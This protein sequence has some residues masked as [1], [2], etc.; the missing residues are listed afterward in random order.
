MVLLVDP[1]SYSVPRPIAPETARSVEIFDNR[2]ENYE[3]AAIEDRINWEKYGDK[4]VTK[5]D[6]RRRGKNVHLRM[7]LLIVILRSGACFLP[8]LIRLGYSRCP[9]VFNRG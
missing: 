4:T 2:L 6:P 7:N 8:L 5:F 9:A 3:F 1:Q